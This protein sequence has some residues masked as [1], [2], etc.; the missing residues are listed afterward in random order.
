MRNLPKRSFDS[1]IKQ[2]EIYNVKFWYLSYI[3]KVYRIESKIYVSLWLIEVFEDKYPIKLFGRK[4][5]KI[6][7]LAH[8]LLNYIQGSIYDKDGYFLKEPREDSSGIL[9]LN[10]LLHRSANYKFSGFHKILSKT[11]YWIIPNDFEALKGFRYYENFMYYKGKEIQII[12]P[13]QIIINYFFFNRS[14][15]LNQ[16]IIENL[17][18]SNVKNHGVQ[19][20][21]E[22]EWPNY[23]YDGSD[24]LVEYV[25]HYSFD[26]SKLSS[27]YAAE[28]AKFFYT[29]RNAGND[30][31]QKLC[32][33]HLVDFY[34][35]K[36]DVFLDTRIPF[37]MLSNFRIC[38]QFIDNEEK[39][40]MANRITGFKSNDANKKL[41]MV[42]FMIA[43]VLN[44]TRTAIKLEKRE[45]INKIINLNTFVSVGDIVT[46][47]PSN[48]TAPIK[49]NDRVSVYQDFLMM[50][51][52]NILSQKYSN[53]FRYKT[54]V[55]KGVEIN[56]QTSNYT[57]FDPSSSLGRIDQTIT[58][59]NLLECNKYAK[60][61]L[62]NV[63]KTLDCVGNYVI[64]DKNIYIEN[65]N[66][67]G[68]DILSEKKY[69]DKVYKFI[70]FEIIL[71]F[72]YFYFV[73]MGRGRY[74][75]IFLQ[76]TGN[77]RYQKIDLNKLNLILKFASENNFHWSKIYKDSY[78]R[79]Q[80][81]GI[82]VLRPMEH[83]TIHGD[84]DDD[85]KES[86]LINNLTSKIIKRI[87]KTNRF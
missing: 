76:N 24:P 49:K 39:I 4:Y 64:L 83:E 17:V 33:K 78:S 86:I 26:I 82:T 38:G 72:D 7:L 21:K 23:V 40:F 42:D 54:S 1:E 52:K 84:Q 68:K 16:N 63:C 11:N 59:A 57:D 29:N 28:I 55:K 13:L 66:T 67:N 2:K 9:N 12:I 71:D 48:S 37:E 46:D 62:E 41:Y 14:S 36:K 30:S 45:E 25:G 65:T 75:A 85:V 77:G 20:R 43:G 44:D 35:G 32:C 60:A 73:E 6:K 53:Y 51:P 3:G 31:L 5:L 69:N 10:V 27:S 56:G 47:E 15:N 58:L 80:N 70:L 19:I 50:S 18:L 81:N 8:N 79:L 74:S 87:K 22:E 34:N 61:A